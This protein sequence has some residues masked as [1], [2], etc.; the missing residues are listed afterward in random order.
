MPTQ[1]LTT[2]LPPVTPTLDLGS[3]TGTYTAS[4][5][6]KF[7]ESAT[8]TEG[9]DK[10]LG[11][12]V[13]IVSGS[14]SLG[15][16]E[17][18]ALKLDGTIGTID[19]KYTSGNKV[20]RLTDNTTGGTATASEFQSVLRLMGISG[21]T[22]DVNIS[23]NLGRPTFSLE[24][25][26]YYEFVPFTSSSNLNWTQS[27]I[28]AEGKSFLGLNGYLVSITTQSEN[29][30]LANSFESK[31]WIGGEAT[32]V[33]GTR[34]WKW[35]GTASPEEGKSFWTGSAGGTTTGTNIGYANW[36]S[37]EPNDFTP[38]EPYAHFL[39]SGKWNDHTLT[40]PG[41]ADPVRRPDGYWVEYSTKS[42]DADT[43]GSTRD[44]VSLTQGRASTAP[45][46]VFYD[47]ASG[48]VSFA[49]VGANNTI[50]N[51][52]LT[53]DTPL[54]TLNPTTPYPGYAD[55]KSVV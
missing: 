20:L 13:R 44:T 51:E 22:G 53:G 17:N 26:H 14:A 1:E 36:D 47:P 33:N 6:T 15:I 29:D 34:T 55:R 12:Q 25:G 39:A 8:V 10:I 3:P 50:A 37:G 28:A 40:G 42:G 30:F 11:L 49:F 5:F 54:L 46:L 41:D 9:S 45:D 16:V 27:K 23:A 38:G 24:N 21:A 31:G 4:G 35:V 32:D 7:A 2:L 52:G 48:K 43:L 18:G 19:Y